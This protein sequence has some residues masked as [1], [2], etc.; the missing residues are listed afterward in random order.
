MLL[1]TG[2]FSLLTI[3]ADLEVG[4]WALRDPQALQQGQ[5]AISG[6]DVNWVTLPV[7][8]VNS[9]MWGTLPLPNFLTSQLNSRDPNSPFRGR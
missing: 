1:L 2:L 5:S 3:P 6:S 7:N 4:G 8:G 9:E